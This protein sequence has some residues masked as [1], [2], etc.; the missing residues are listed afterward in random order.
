MEVLEL[1]FTFLIASDSWGRNQ[2]RLNFVLVL[3]SFLIYSHSLWTACIAWLLNDLISMPSSGV[4]EMRIHSKWCSASKSGRTQNYSLNTRRCYWGH[5]ILRKLFCNLD[6]HFLGVGDIVSLSHQVCMSLK[7]GYLHKA[8]D[9]HAV[10]LAAAINCSTFEKVVLS[11]LYNHYSDK[12][13][14]WW[15]RLRLSQGKGSME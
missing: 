6:L 9:W 8:L 5:E 15:M 10:T 4:K 13:L 12:N 2:E 7:C 3:H 1:Q 11:F 14:S